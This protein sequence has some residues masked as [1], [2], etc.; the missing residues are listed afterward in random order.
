MNSMQVV[1][2]PGSIQTATYQ[3]ISALVSAEVGAGAIPV[4]DGDGAGQAMA[5][6]IHVEAGAMAGAILVGAGVIQ[7][8]AGV[9]AGAITLLTMGTIPMENDMPTI[10]AGLT[11][12]VF[13]MKEL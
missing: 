9:Q 1:I 8:G 6:A 5:G 4:M 3:S 7:V 10:R 12:E 2:L 13:I 11:R